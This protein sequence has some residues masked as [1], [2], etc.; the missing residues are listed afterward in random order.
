MKKTIIWNSPNSIF[1]LSCKEHH[2]NVLFKNNIG[3]N[4][5]FEE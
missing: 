1:M 5:V 2:K 4:P 3:S